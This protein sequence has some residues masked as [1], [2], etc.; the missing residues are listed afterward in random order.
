MKLYHWSVEISAISPSDERYSTTW[1]TQS[2]R[3]MAEAKTR[4]VNEFEAVN[5]G[6]KATAKKAYLTGAV[7]EG[8]K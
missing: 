8:A 6:W 7:K 4:A 3:K 1:P 2:G 5:K